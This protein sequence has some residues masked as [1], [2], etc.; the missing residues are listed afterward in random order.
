MCVTY[1]YTADQRAGIMLEGFCLAGPVPFTLFMAV[2]L[3]W[4]LGNGKDPALLFK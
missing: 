2:G 1:V 3:S 4:L